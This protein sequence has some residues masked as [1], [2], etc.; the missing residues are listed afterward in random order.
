MAGSSSFEKQSM[1]AFTVRS[2]N[3]ILEIHSVSNS[4]DS[5]PLLLLIECTIQYKNASTKIRKLSLLLVA[6]IIFTAI[7][8]RMSIKSNH[9]LDCD[10]ISNWLRESNSIFSLSFLTS[11]HVPYPNFKLHGI[12]SKMK[13]NTPVI[14]VCVSPT[15]VFFLSSNKANNC[16]EKYSKNIVACCNHTLALS[17]AKQALK[18]KRG[19][20]LS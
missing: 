11:C 7:S 16:P 1:K 8:L 5:V 3:R 15:P 14:H 19:N 10:L 4:C 2:F 13:C 6:V 18:I 9:F 12:C 20:I 17:R